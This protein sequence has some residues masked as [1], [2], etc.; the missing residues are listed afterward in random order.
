MSSSNSFMSDSTVVSSDRVIYTP[1]DFART[2]LNYLQ[3]VGRLTALQIHE[4]HRRELSSYLFFMVLS[5]SGILTV[6]GI[7]YDMH[8][9]DCA[10]V[11][12][13]QSYTHKSS[14]DLWELKWVHFNGPTMI[15]I[16]N[17]Y[18]ERGGHS[19]FT[20]SQ[21]EFQKLSD[22]LSSIQNTAASSSYIRDMEINEQLTS[23]LTI[24]MCNSWN[25][26]QSKKASAKRKDLLSIREYLDSHYTET[27][28]LDEV[29]QKFYINKYYLTRIFKE[30]Y[31]TTISNYLTQLRITN[32]K[33]H[34]RYTD[35]S[36]EQVGAMCSYKDAN[37][38][39][40]TFKGLEGVTPGEFRR[41]WR[42]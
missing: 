1:S 9:G 31:G 38:F 42:A 20:P 11:D 5:G 40:R 14:S 27:I 18:W 29:A 6:E 15:G 37:F 26:E 24:L 41:K 21:Q 17:K 19:T 23:L 4:S 32:A 28:K 35:Y 12:C 33:K 3:E 30:Q 7:T 34:L 36:I 39:I 16:Y 8:A 22:C 10:F 25:P 2:N 13:M